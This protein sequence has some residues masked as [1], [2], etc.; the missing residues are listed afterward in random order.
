[1]HVLAPCDE[2]QTLAR[3]RELHVVAL[4]H[5]GAF[6]WPGAMQRVRKHPWRA[7]G[8]MA[9]AAHA[10]NEVRRLRPDRIV[11]HWMVPCG[12]PIG[13]TLMMCGVEAQLELVAHG[14]D[15][16]LLLALPKA[17]REGILQRIVDCRA[18]IRFA[19]HAS[20]D[21]LAQCVNARLRQQLRAR[22][23]VRQCE[24]VI[25]DVSID[26]AQIRQQ[27]CG[28]ALAVTVSRLVPGKRVDLA[29]DAL[30]LC[31]GLELCVLGDGPERNRLQRLGRGAEVR[32]VGNVKRNCALAWIGAADVLVHTSQHEAA[33]T[34][35]REARMMGVPVVACEAGDVLRWSQSDAGIRCVPADARII[36]DA[37]GAVLRL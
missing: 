23:T 18:T 7:A 19:A 9:F 31:R 27:R 12:Y 15:V 13:T 22:A 35:V 16:R 30:R 20:F 26:T 28:G 34:V 6:G 14:G 17:V 25:P 21:S 33:P 32:F 8:M 1:M 4:R 5:G 10:I 36:A 3:D 29:I 11:A 24:I 37:I 2:T